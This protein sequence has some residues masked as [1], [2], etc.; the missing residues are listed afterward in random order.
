MLTSTRNV[1]YSD[2]TFLTELVSFTSNATNSF[3]IES[4]GAVA[5]SLDVS[6]L[7]GANK[8]FYF[9]NTSGQFTISTTT[10]TV[11]SIYATSTTATSTFQG[12]I[13]DKSNKSITFHVTSVTAAG[14]FGRIWK[15]QR[16]IT[17]Q[18][19]TLNQ[20]GA[21]NVIGQLQECDSN[22]AN[23]AAIDSSDITGT[24][25]ID[26]VDDGSLS[27][28]SVDE[29]DYIGWT[30]TSVSGTNTRMAVTFNYVENF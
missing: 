29:Q 23:C 8:T 7:T 6:Q 4:T 10:T 15:V 28:S 3:E 5:A 11:S 2:D 19:V 14:D 30:T 16:N 12:S 20:E 17:I 25:G 24:D 18:K 22:G 9:P 27:N 21:T 26:V 13:R 1:W